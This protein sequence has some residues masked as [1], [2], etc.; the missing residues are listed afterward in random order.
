MPTTIGQLDAQ[1][2]LGLD[3]LYATTQRVGTGSSTPR[4]PARA[5]ARLTQGP[6]DAAY[7]I[8]GDTVVRVDPVSGAVDDGHL[9]GRGPG[10]GMAAP[11]LLARGGPDLLVVDV[12][13]GLWRWRP[14]GALGQVRLSG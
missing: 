1:L 13:G 10:Q 8:V 14:S 7:A 4:P 5:S 3:E 9:Y 2:R 12:N 11:R 6:D